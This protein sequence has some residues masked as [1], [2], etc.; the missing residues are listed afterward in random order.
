[1]K[2]FEAIKTSQLINDDVKKQELS[3]SILENECL[4]FQCWNWF[5]LTLML[6]WYNIDLML[7]WIE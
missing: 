2:F 5:D 6:V 7:N 4:M 1:M 3:F